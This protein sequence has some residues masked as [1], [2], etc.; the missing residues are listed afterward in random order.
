MR[1]RTIEVEAGREKIVFVCDVCGT[2]ATQ[3]NEA[4]K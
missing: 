2:E 3:D 1:I 4:P